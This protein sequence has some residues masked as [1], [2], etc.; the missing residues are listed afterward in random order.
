MKSLKQTV[1]EIKAIVKQEGNHNV[2]TLAS[3]FTAYP[4]TDWKQHI[5]YE[6]GVPVTTVLHQDKHLKMLLICWEGGQKSKKHGHPEG[7]GLIRVLSGTLLE[8]RFAP[9]DENRMTGIYDYTARSGPAYIH[10][11][12]AFHIV[13]NAT[14]EPAVSL[15]LY[16]YGLTVSKYQLETSLEQL[17]QKLRSAA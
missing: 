10:D 1:E 14:D 3:L 7:G 11:S 8:T 12:E 5:N 15:H 13:E 4:G 6:N 17:E 2:R 16:S 9:D